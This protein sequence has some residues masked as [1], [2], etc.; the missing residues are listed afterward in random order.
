[1]SNGVKQA[2]P[3][4]HYYRLDEQIGYILR[5]VSQRHTTL[6]SSMIGD[7]LKPRQWAV[8]AR[9]HEIG[10]ASQ[11][12]LGRAVAMD[13]ATVKGTVERLE[14]RGLAR[15]VRDPEDGRKLLVTLTPI[16]RRVTLRNMDRAIA[17]TRETVAPLSADENRQLVRLL[18][19]LR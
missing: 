11:A 2:L 16:G 4:P 7:G 19:R 13:A 14:R 9:L 12:D 1:M 3:M 18:A 8:L 5:Q 6:F 10:T 17:I 15:R